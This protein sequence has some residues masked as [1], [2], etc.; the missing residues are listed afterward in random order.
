MH[1]KCG[2][3]YHWIPELYKRMKLPVFDGVP[4]ALERYSIQRKRALDKAKTEQQKMTQAK[5][6]ALFYA[7]LRLHLCAFA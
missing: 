7:R 3:Q 2:T 6:R 4:E 5:K 1:E